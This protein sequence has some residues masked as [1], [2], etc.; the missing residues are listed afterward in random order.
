[1]ANLS[2]TEHVNESVL[3]KNPEMIKK[4][5]EK[6]PDCGKYLPG[7]KAY[8]PEITLNAVKSDHR[9]FVNVSDEFKEKFPILPMVVGEWSIEKL[10]KKLDIVPIVSMVS[11]LVRIILSIYQIAYSIIHTYCFLSLDGYEG[12]RRSEIKSAFM[13][14]GL[15]H[16]GKNLKSGLFFL[17][18]PLFSNWLEYED[19]RIANLQLF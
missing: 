11:G 9:E 15:H 19:R 1:M 2:R 3:K 10:L 5:L 6:V 7:S 4:A 16:A 14:A 18:V 13:D 8:F 17:M 12:T